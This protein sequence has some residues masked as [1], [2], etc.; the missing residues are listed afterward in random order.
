MRIE[1]LINSFWRLQFIGWLIYLFFIYVTFL[2]VAQPGRFLSL[3]YLKGFRAI[4][5]LCLTSVLWQVYK[6]IIDRFSISGIVVSVVILSIIFGTLWTG[7]EQIYVWLTA[8]NYNFYATLPRIPRIALD[9]AVTTTAWSAIYFG[10][11]YWQQ[12]QTERENALEANILAEKAQ[13][14]MLRYQVNPHFLFNAMNSIRAS[15]DEDRHRAKE[16][17]TQLSEFM[18]HSL[19]SGSNKTI[20]LREELEAVRNYLAIEKIRFEDRLETIFD[21]DEKAED[22]KIPCFLLNPLIENAIKHGFTTSPEI[23]QVKVSAKLEDH[24][25][26]IGITNTGKLDKTLESTGTQIGLANVR[27]R[28]AKLFPGRSSFML[29]ETEGLVSAKI[30]IRQ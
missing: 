27:E 6:R 4:V 15:I 10:I 22:I 12:W 5:G 18:R 29:T 11:K 28:L 20:A 8:E 13:L 30:E 17:I 7:I 26:L 19:L 2:S 9:Y 23:L 25:L 14:D 3:F 16:M 21:V 1:S 24:R